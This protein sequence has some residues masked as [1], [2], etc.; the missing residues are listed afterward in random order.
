MLYKNLHTLLF[1][2]Y[3]FQLQEK[4]E[5]QFAVPQDHLPS[6]IPTPQENRSSNE[7]H[8]NPNQ[9]IN[10]VSAAYSLPNL[11]QYNIH[12][13]NMETSYINHN[14]SQPNRMLGPF[15]NNMNINQLN[16][17]S[18][19]HSNN[20]LHGVNANINHGLQNQMWNGQALNNQVAPGNRANN[21]WDNFRR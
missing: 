9:K 16:A 5:N 11:N 4:V 8:V 2:F 19:D 1:S 12:P 17:Q 15:L 21:Y 3:F 6:T 18:V 20:D 13:S 14:N 7:F 10:H